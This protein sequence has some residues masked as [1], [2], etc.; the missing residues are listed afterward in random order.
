MFHNRRHKGGK[1]RP[2]IDPKFLPCVPSTAAK[3][4]TEDISTANVV[5]HTAIAQRK[6]EG[7]DMISDD[8]VRGV[9]TIG[10][11]CTKSTLVRPDASQ[12]PNL[13]EYRGEDVGVVI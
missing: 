11:L 1:K 9:D 2:D 12:F 4:S 7:P 13:F 5:G 3:D 10:I 6:G 8:T